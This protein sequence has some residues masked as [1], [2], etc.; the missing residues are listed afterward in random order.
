MSCWRACCPRRPGRRRGGRDCPKQSI[1]QTPENLNDADHGDSGDG[2]TSE[3][4]EANP[5]EGKIDPEKPEEGDGNEDTPYKIGTV[6]ELL[7]FAG[8]VNGTL[9]HNAG[10]SEEGAEKNSAAWAVLT[11]NIDLSKVCRKDGRSWTPIGSESNPYTGTF[12]GGG[13]T[14]EGLYVDNST[15]NSETYVGLFGVVGE[16]GTVKNLTVAGEVTGSDGRDRYNFTYTG[17]VAGQ[18]YGTVAGCS[19]AVIGTVT[20]G[21]CYTYV[22]G[23]VGQNH[24]TVADCRNNGT[25]TAKKINTGDESYIGGVVG[26]NY[27]TVA[28]CCNTGAVSSTGGNTG[29]S[30]GGVAGESTE[31]TI[32]NCYN[33][34]TVTGSSGQDSSTGGVVGESAEGTIEN[35]YNTGT[36]TGSSGQNSSTGGVAGESAGGTIENCYNTGTV[37]GGSGQDSSTGGVAGECAGGTIRNCY[38]LTG[39]CYPGAGIGNDDETASK[40]EG[41]EKGAFESG[42]VAYLL[43]GSV[44]EETVPWRQNL[45]SDK[46][47]DCFPVLAALDPGH[48]IVYQTSD[49]GY[50]NDPPAAPEQPSS[51]GGSST[52]TYRPDVEQPENGAVS[53]SPRNPERG[54][55]VTITQAPEEG[56]EVDEVIVTDRNGDE[57]EVTENRDGTWTFEQPRGRVTISVTFRELPPEPIPFPDVPEDHW[58]YDAIQYVCGKG[59][60]AGT[61]A[62]A[63]SPDGVLTRGQLVTILWRLAGSPQVNYLMDFSDVDP[64]AWY[65]EA[66][67]WASA[68]RIVSGYGDGRFGP[69]DSVTREQLAVMLYQYAW[70]M[71]YDL[72]A[73]GMALREFDDYGAISGWALEALDWAVSQG[74]VGGI[75]PTAFDPQG[76]ATRAQAAVMLE[77][78]CGLDKG[79]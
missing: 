56:F 63:F 32:E 71:G 49:G 18:N 9:G 39:E 27:G 72:T 51:G 15:S 57:V 8:L 52:P 70:N 19:F 38:Y 17:G 42:E 67:R 75:S 68:L 3:A 74:I 54:D 34:G 78:F 79:I 22:G 46:T 45:G 40:V 44:S 48:G 77:R 69:D 12:D 30:T 66:V 2:S 35:C 65:G 5:D 7:W 14:I 73:G 64:A 13:N 58:A 61:G 4:P 21:D 41:K 62:D 6:E 25:V 29:G 1:S 76:L 33:T 20:G 28:D 26:E 60:M 16:D 24:G 23:V 31:G 11:E 55:D 50:S 43:N 10:T 37:T 36:V 59:L 47:A 53:V